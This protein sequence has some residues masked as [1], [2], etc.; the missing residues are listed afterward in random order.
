MQVE[1]EAWEPRP[2]VDARNPFKKF[3]GKFVGAAEE[4]GNYF[5]G[6]RV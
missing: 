3:V 1:V 5:G 6:F 4:L 2:Y